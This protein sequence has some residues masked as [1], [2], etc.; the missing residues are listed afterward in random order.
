MPSGGSALQVVDPPEAGFPVAFEDLTALPDAAERFARI[1]REVEGAPFRLG[2]EP[3]AR[4]CLVALEP[5]HHVLLLTAHHIIFDGWSRSLL[6]RELGL[7]YT[8]LAAGAGRRRC[9]N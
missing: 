7:V 6:L 4:G 8:A 9:R 1:R 2:E 3:M 5:D